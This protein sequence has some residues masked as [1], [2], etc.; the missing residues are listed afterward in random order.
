MLGEKGLPCS[1][2]YSLQLAYTYFDP[3][4]QTNHFD[5]QA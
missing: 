5:L 3:L 2:R 1:I 4:D